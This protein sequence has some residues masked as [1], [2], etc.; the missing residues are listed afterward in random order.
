MPGAITATAT[1]VNGAV[2]T[3]AATATDIVDGA[4]T[5]VCKPASGSTFA[6]GS[7][8]VTCTA[9][10]AHGNQSPPGTF[11]VQAQYAWSGF[12]QPINVDGSSVFKLGSTVPVKFQL[13][14]AS[15]AITNASAN[16][17]V[18]QISS[19]VTGSDVEAV[20]TS[21]ATTGN[22]F[23]YDSGGY[24]F[25]LSTKPLSKGT[26]QLKVDLHDGVS[27]IVDISLR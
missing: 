25:N 26:W 15:G 24:I 20:S 7:T 2:V 8:S 16:L 22:A 1:S 18:A 21:A 9:T 13:T 19:N 3:H 12:L 17:T 11:T 14:G 27:R 4:V 10:D 5:P 6:L 23:R